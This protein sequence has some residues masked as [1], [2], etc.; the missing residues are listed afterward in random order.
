METL[1]SFQYHLLQ[2]GTDADDI[3]NRAAILIHCCTECSNGLMA[4]MIVIPSA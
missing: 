4:S 3:S 2:L 1:K